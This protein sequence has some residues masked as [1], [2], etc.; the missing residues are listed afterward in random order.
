M[1]Y[2]GP[3]GHDNDWKSKLYQAMSLINAKRTPL[4]VR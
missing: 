1:D 2:P 4:E 3:V